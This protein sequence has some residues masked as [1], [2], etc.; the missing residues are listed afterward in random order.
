MKM[1]T[2]FISK[3]EAVFIYS[4]LTDPE[5]NEQSYAKNYFSGLQNSFAT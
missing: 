2:I 5:N 1:N 3:G 4:K